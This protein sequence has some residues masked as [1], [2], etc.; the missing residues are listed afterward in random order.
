M[1]ECSQFPLSFHSYLQRLSA[2]NNFCL[3]GNNCNS[4]SEVK[5]AQR[6]AKSQTRLS[7]FH[8]TLQSMEFFTFT[9]LY[10]PWNS[11]GQNT[12]V[13]S[14]SLLQGIFP[15]QRS[16][17]GLPHYRQIL[18][19]LNHQGSPTVTVPFINNLLWV[20]PCCNYSDFPLLSLLLLLP[21][22]QKLL[23]AESL[24]K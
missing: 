13:G 18:Y 23:I 4:E 9:S 3:W 10:S 14:L 7:N 5:V 24:C 17:P 15:T 1:S 19:Q 11:P 16:K 2:I 20:K 21:K 6:V 8:S 22:R 12:G